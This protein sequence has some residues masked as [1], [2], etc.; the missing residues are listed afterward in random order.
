MIQTAIQMGVAGM[1]Y[2]FSQNLIKNLY[3]R[4]IFSSHKP[5]Q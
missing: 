4:Y 5:L 2:V 3:D 1:W